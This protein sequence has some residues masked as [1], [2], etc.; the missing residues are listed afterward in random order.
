MNFLLQIAKAMWDSLQV[1]NEGTNEVKQGRVNIVNQEFEF[2]H[3]KYGEI[4]VDMQKRSTHLINRLNAFGKL[5]SQ[6][7]CFNREWKPKVTAIMEA[8]DLLTLD[9]TIFLEILKNVSKSLCA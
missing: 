2:F 5:V 3:M 4:I 6:E 8:N 7:R 9:I 1:A